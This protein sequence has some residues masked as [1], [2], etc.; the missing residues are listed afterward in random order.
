MRVLFVVKNWDTDIEAV[1]LNFAEARSK[2][3][4]S[5]WDEIDVWFEDLSNAG[6]FNKRFEIWKKIERFGEF[7]GVF[8]KDCKNKKRKEKIVC[9]TL[10]DFPLNEFFI[11]KYL[12]SGYAYLGG[13]A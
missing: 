3:M 12:P 6:N 9:E 1:T 5:K 7:G 11:N 13:F 2:F 10:K 4:K 8:L